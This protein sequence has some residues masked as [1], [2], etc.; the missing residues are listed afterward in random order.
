MCGLLCLAADALG[1]NAL[2]LLMGCIKQSDG[3][4]GLQPINTMQYLQ[5][6]RGSRNNPI[7]NHGRAR[8]LLQKLRHRMLAIH[9]RCG[10]AG[11]GPA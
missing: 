6:A 4:N 8:G 1:G 9:V 10:A 5:L 3:T 11:P 7:I 2:T